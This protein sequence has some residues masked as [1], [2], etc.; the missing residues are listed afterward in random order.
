MEQEGNPM[1]NLTRTIRRNKVKAYQGNNRIA[2]AWHRLMYRVLGRD[3]KTVYAKYHGKR[4]ER[5]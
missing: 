5:R 3:Y 1:S 2:K 4:E